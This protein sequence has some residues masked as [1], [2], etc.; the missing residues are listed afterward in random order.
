MS[1]ID[2][3]CVYMLYCTDPYKWSCP[4][5][6]IVTTRV[7]SG[8][9]SLESVFVQ[10]LSDHAFRMCVKCCKR[11]SLA[12]SV[13]WMRQCRHACQEVLVPPPCMMFRCLDITQQAWRK[14]SIWRI[15][16][17]LTPSK[18]KRWK[19]IQPRAIYLSPPAKP[20]PH[21]AQSKRVNSTHQR[22]S[23]IYGDV[24]RTDFTL[25]RHVGIWQHPL[26]WICD[27]QHIG[28]QTCNIWTLHSRHGFHSAI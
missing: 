6:Q 25:I 15:G 8:S 2:F 28:S 23:R 3:T 1:R 22:C 17:P 11:E 19:Q 13:G 9:F 10:A 12:Y 4:I 27:F 26:S 7:N 24:S 5:K 20:A 18:L 21:T 14:L 16:G